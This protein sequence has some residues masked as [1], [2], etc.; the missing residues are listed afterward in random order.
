MTY[1][2]VIAGGSGQRAGQ[3]V[4]KQFLTVNEI[5][6]IIHTLKNIQNMQCIDEILVVIPEGWEKFIF[7]YA[8]QYGISK[9]KKC[10]LGGATRFKSIKNAIEYLSE[11]ALPDSIVSIMDANRPLVPEKTVRESVEKSEENFCCL[12]VDSCYDTMYISEN[13][14]ISD[15]VDRAKLFKGQTPET[16]KLFEVAKVY[17]D[18]ENKGDGDLATSMLYLK[19][20]KRV[21]AIQGSALSFKI[22]TA[23]DIDLFRAF[24][25]LN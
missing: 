13:G 20:G 16:V 15:T 19:Y 3:H 9:L 17:E 25:N 23:E 5:P 8:E 12:A 18:A 14:H 6:I 21:K 22:T 1:A 4:P 2:V 24:V 7:A 10:V 11:T